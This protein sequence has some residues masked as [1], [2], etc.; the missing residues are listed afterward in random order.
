MTLLKP[1]FFRISIPLLILCLYI[2]PLF[3]QSS[4]DNKDTVNLLVITGGPTLRHQIDLVP[5]SFYSL[6]MDKKNLQW[7]HATR[8]EAALQSGNLQNYDV[9]L[10]YN[11]S[12]SIS[13]SSKKNLRNFLESGKGLIVL[14]H[15][16][17]SYNDWE[18]WYKDVI[19]AKYQMNETEQYPKSDF[20]QGETIKMIPA[21]EHPFSVGLGE[22]TLTD[23]TY[24]KLWISDQVEVLYETDNETSDG[25]TVWI[26][27]YSKS[28]V[29]V[30]Q[31]GHAASAHLNENYQK[32][33][34]NAVFWAN[35]N[36]ME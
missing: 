33:I 13:D 11:R 4:S 25:P 1:L 2:N 20:L 22:F 3:S 19:G 5:T 36:S 17:G 34:Y 24:K 18:W 16:L 35:G 28:R 7:D 27:P 15:A 21:K 26:S 9:L 29:L 30:I 12:D 10:F 32:L 8:D 31:P 6:F 14:H 23:E